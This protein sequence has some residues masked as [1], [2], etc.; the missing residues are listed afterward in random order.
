MKSSTRDKAE[1]T[2]R[3]IAGSM[4]ETAG[5]VIGNP[6]LEAAGKAGKIGGRIQKKVGELKQ[7]LGG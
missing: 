3:H 2:A 7:V 5:K 4:K 6:R 1:G